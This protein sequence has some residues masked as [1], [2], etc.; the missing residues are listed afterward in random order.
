MRI[1]VCG[2]KG[3]SGKSTLAG[4]LALCFADVG[5]RI[6]AIDKDPQATLT[7]WLRSIGGKATSKSGV[8]WTSLNA[9]AK[10]EQADD[11]NLGWKKNCVWN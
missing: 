7:T 2:T 9:E 6:H 8:P 11:S 3:G 4:L 1:A 5:K 10:N